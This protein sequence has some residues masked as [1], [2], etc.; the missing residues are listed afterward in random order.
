[1]LLHLSLSEQR[2]KRVH[3]VLNEKSSLDTICGRSL[4][5]TFP[6]LGTEGDLSVAESLFVYLALP[7]RKGCSVCPKK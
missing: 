6:C 3:A 4:I 7:K 2:G 5:L 1:M